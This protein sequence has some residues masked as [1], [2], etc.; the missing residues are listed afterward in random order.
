MFYLQNNK[1]KSLPDEFF[2]SFPNLKWLDLRDNE[3]LEIQKSVKNHRSLTHLLLKNNKITSLP[4]EL[5]TVATLKILLLSGNPIMYPPREVIKAGTPQ[6]LEFL[7]N[8]FIEELFE[9]SRSVL[10]DKASVNGDCL[11]KFLQEGRSYNSVIDGAKLHQKLSVQFNERD[12]Y[13]SDD[14]EYYAKIKGK[15][16]KLPKSRTKILPPYSQSAKYLKPLSTCPKRVQDQKMKQNFFKELALKKQRDLFEKREKILQGRR[17]TSILVLYR[18]FVSILYFLKYLF[19]FIFS[20]LSSGVD[21]KRAVEFRQSTHNAFR[22]RRK[23]R[24]GVS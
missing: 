6:I 4:N 24:N 21:A 20:F 23:V 19:T 1:L 7:N 12:T 8:K 10:S 17:Y 14:E 13:D 2:P 16:P 5:G 11:Q 9:E 22:T 3:L 18:I 15:C